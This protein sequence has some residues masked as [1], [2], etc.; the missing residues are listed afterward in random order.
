MTD[1]S[2]VVREEDK[3]DGMKTGWGKFYRKLELFALGDP[4]KEKLL[5]GIKVVMNDGDDPLPLK[6]LFKQQLLKIVGQPGAVQER[7]LNIEVFNAWK[8]NHNKISSNG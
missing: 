7:H 5:L 8:E 3:Y 2:E 1:K 4:I 6:Y